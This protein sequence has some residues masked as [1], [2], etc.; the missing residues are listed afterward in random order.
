MNWSAIVLRSN[1][2][3]MF[4]WQFN[5]YNKQHLQLYY[6]VAMG[7][8]ISTFLENFFYV[9]SYNSHNCL[10]SSLVG[11]LDC[12]IGSSTELELETVIFSLSIAATVTN[13]VC[14]CRRD[15]N[16][17]TWI[18]KTNAKSRFFNDISNHVKHIYNY[19]TYTLKLFLHKLPITRWTICI[20]TV[21]MWSWL[22]TVKWKLN[23]TQ[24]I[25]KVAVC[26]LNAL[27]LFENNNVACH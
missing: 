27:L 7:K 22:L 5:I 9:F 1:V 3:V 24:R 21:T 26:G 15:Y 11:I 14:W 10:L 12:T 25:M 2:L 17:I 18:F 8:L 6:A 13:Y 23:K 4:R 16:C 19:Y 20:N